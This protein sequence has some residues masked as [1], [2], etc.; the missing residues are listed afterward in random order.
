MFPFIIHY[1]A[2][3]A[4]ERERNESTPQ[5]AHIAANIVYLLQKQYCFAKPNIFD[6]TLKLL[7]LRALSQWL[8]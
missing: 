7:S 6:N 3:A 2:A 8:S 5:C 1:L 4:A